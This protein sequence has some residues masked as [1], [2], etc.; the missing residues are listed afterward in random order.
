MN[1]VD[2][3]IPPHQPGKF[4][5]YMLFA[6]KGRGFANLVGPVFGSEVEA[7]KRNMFANN[8]KVYVLEETVFINRFEN[9]YW[10]HLENNW[11][12]KL[13]TYFILN[14]KWIGKVTLDE[15]IKGFSS[16]WFTMFET[17]DNGVKYLQIQCR[18]GI[19]PFLEPRLL[20]EIQKM[21]PFRVKPKEEY[22]NGNDNMLYTGHRAV[23]RLLAENLIATVVLS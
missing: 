4:I 9:R 12:D 14:R 21:L 8:K 5:T 2:N 16:P 23:R 15:E 3:K 6:K 7:V 17:V 10:K 18:T 1:A 11:P 19:D 13:F 22:F 20:L